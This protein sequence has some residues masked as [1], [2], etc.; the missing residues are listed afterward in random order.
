MLLVG[1]AS[2]C[3]VGF[4]SPNFGA[5]DGEERIARVVVCEYQ[6]DDD[7][8]VPPVRARFQ[9]MGCPPVVQLV[10]F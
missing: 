2:K 7:I 1:P 6:C 4:E 9:T 5:E 3:L 10:P 8:C